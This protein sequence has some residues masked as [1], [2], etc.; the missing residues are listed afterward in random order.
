VSDG[1]DLRLEAWKTFLRGRIAEERGDP[2][3]ALEAYDE[4][5]AADPGNEAFQRSRANALSGLGRPDDGV[6]ARIASQYQT[7]AE[8]LVGPDDEPD[9]WIQS[10]ERLLSTA[11]QAKERRPQVMMVW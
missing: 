10:L 9:A 2:E 11:E 8:Q 1:G 4:A 6:A 5:L 7:L 3:T